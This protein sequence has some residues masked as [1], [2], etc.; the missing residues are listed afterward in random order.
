LKFNENGG[1]EF[2]MKHA[3]RMMVGAAILMPGIPALAFAQYQNYENQQPGYGQPGYA[4]P[5]YGQPAY[6]TPGAAPGQSGYSG[7]PAQQGYGIPQ[8]GSAVP[9]SPSYSSA[10][11]AVG[12][13]AGQAASKA[14]GGTTGTAVSGAIGAVTSGST[15]SPS[16][17]Q[18][19]P[20][21]GG[22]QQPG[23]GT[24]AQPPR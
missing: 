4:Q 17:V 19:Q 3:V 22:Y 20:A 9:G 5:G 18:P 24:P 14:L 1:R 12:A 11:Q 23:Y 21:Y 6:A 8:Q 10:T 16:V 2:F 13:A 15:P 7:Y